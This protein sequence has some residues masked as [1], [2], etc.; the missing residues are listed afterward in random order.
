MNK[1]KKRL[2]RL[3]PLYFRFLCEECKS[4]EEIWLRDDEL[5]ALFL[6][7]FQGLY[8]DECARAMGISRP[9]FSKMLKAARRKS[10]DFFIHGKRLRIE[11]TSSRFVLAFPTHDRIH[12]A[13]SLLEA[14]FLGFA[15]VE[16]GEI[17]ALTYEENPLPKEENGCLGGGGG[18]GRFKLLAPL[19]QGSSLLVVREIGEGF[20]RNL[21]SLGLSVVV[22][23]KIHLDEVM[24]EI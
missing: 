19:L 13:P 1:T 16:E 8:H 17:K 10:V 6:A 2:K 14:K 24:Q 22:S 15:Q 4:E 5:E 23:S 3:K 7:D 21:E 20:K 9:T 18:G 12:L 11:K